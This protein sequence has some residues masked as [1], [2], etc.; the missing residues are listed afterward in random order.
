MPTLSI[1]VFAAT[2]LSEA[3][4]PARSVTMPGYFFDEELEGYPLEEIQPSIGT[5]RLE[6]TDA[7]E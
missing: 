5:G 2:M 1:S 4:I 7:G 6:L 3:R